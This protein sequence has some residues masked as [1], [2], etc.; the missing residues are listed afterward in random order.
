M[1]KIFT[2]LLA[3]AGLSLQAQQ[4][5]NAD[6]NGEWI[7]NVTWPTSA[8]RGTTPSGWQISHV[9]GANGLGATEVGYKDE[10]GATGAAVKLVNTANPLMKSQIVPAYLTL[11]TT[12]NTS[13]GMFSITNKD[14]GSFGG[15]Q[16]AYRPDALS[17][18]YKRTA[19]DASVPA[20]VLA[21]LW[22][23]TWTQKDV[24]ATIATT[25]SP[26]KYEMTDRDRN[27]LGKSYSQGGEVSATADAKLIATVE[28]SILNVTEEWTEQ[29]YEFSYAD[30]DALPEKFNIIFSA[31]DYFDA[32]TVKK[33]NSL[34][35]DDVKLI[36][37]H[38]LT[39]LTYGGKKVTVSDG[40]TAIDLSDVKYDSATALSYVKKGV[41]ATVLAPV[42]DPATAVLTLEVR[43]DDYEADNESKTVYTVQFK[44]PAPAA[45]LSSLTVGGADVDLKEGTTDYTLPFVYNRGLIFD[46]VAAEGSTIE[47]EP[48]F[49]AA[50]R[51]V[52][53]SLKN[54]DG[55]VTDYVFSFTEAV[56]GAETG[57]YKGSLAVTLSNTYGDSSTTSLSN[58]AILITNNANGTVNLALNGFTFAGIPVGD[59]FV[60]NIAVTDGKIDVT[61][62]ILITSL[63]EEGNLDPTGFGAMM[64]MIPVKVVA[65]LDAGQKQTEASI[66]IL[67]SENPILSQMFAGIHV[68]FVPF[69]VEGK[70]VE[71]AI[72]GLSCYSHLAATGRITKTGAR[73]LQLNNRVTYDGE[74]YEIPMSHI[75]LSGATVDADVTLEDIMTG[76]PAVNNTLVYLP[77]GSTITGTNAIVGGKAAVLALTEQAD[78]AAPKAFTAESVTFDRVFATD[79]E[80][81]VPVVMPFATSGFAGKAYQFDSVDGDRLYFTQVSALEANTPYLVSASA[82]APFAGCKDVAVAATPDY[83]PSVEVGSLELCGTFFADDQLGGESAQ[84]FAYQNGLFEK[85]GSNACLPFRALLIGNVVEVTDD[86]FVLYLDNVQTGIIGA[87]ASAPAAK[88]S[89]YTLD[90]KCVR[91]NVSAAASL[92]GLPAGVYIVNGKKVVK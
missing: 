88:V 51:T 82:T 3:C 73:F 47:G 1:K 76:A 40:Q 43:G 63:D 70:V 12:W 2:L 68:D 18:S 56:Q 61:R 4:L 25:G 55:E 5:K 86:S 24:P 92:Q 90:G 14:G 67:T 16:F 21:Y 15:V 59:I 11:G 38:A 53:I 45:S 77:E 17:F 36:Y 91:A 50:K 52:T 32:N 13:K 64:G 49:D 41:G 71:T 29:V 84:A 34:W 6:F 22:K 75:D 33:D 83:H 37:Y 89:V 65:T 23:G 39:S 20:V 80:A 66:D 87:G 9:N 79:A 54:A 74:T 81:L 57:D 27:V 19:A 35:V 10:A 69:E 60:P 48:V 44:V 7:D 30:E 62:P 28:K 58:A 26:T 8:V 46:A 85:L 42:Y 72:S 31:A 78:F